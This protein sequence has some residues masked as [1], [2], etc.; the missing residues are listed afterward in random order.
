MAK[1]P[2]LNRFHLDGSRSSELPSAWLDVF[3]A[4]RDHPREINVQFDQIIIND[5]DE[6]SLQYHTDDFERVLEEPED[7]DPLR[8]INRIL[9]LYLSGK[10]N[11]NR[12][13][14][15]WLQV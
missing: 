7:E 13:L 5:I 10:S 14:K 15:W 11:I 6:I 9:A 4:I 12:P 1:M 2:S 8:D 3:D